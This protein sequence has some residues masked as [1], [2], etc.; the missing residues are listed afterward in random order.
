M[1]VAGEAG[2]R[3]HTLTMTQQIPDN[4]KYEYRAQAAA[5]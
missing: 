1:P 4:Y 2:Y 5:S 3:V